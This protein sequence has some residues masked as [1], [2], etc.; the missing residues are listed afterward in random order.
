MTD[1]TGPTLLHGDVA[2]GDELPRLEV[3]V[4]ATTVV[5]GALASRDWR[6]MHH[7]Y[8]FA[9]NRQGTQNIFLKTFVRGWVIQLDAGRAI[10]CL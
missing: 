2:V 10:P 6:P 9:V 8:E 4:T 3:E 7:D 5:L 1:L